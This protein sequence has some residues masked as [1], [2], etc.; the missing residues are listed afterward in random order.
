MPAILSSHAVDVSPA[1][2]LRAVPSS[3]RASGGVRPAS[4]PTLDAQVGAWADRYRVI[5]G[6][7][8]PSAE[9]PELV[10]RWT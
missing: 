5:V 10:S 4:E 8:A 2:G 6:W 1:A 9:L 3:V 7:C